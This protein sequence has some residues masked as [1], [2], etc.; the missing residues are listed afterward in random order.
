MLS[1]WLLRLKTLVRRERVEAEFDEELRYHLDRE[2]QRNVARGMT[3]TEARRAA[4]RAFGDPGRLKEEARDTW[5]W[6]LL[7][8]FA[9]EARYA[10][11][12]LWHSPGFTVV[13]VLS[14]G[15]GIGSASTLFGV[16]DA[17]DFR[18][19]PFPD[20]ERLVWLAERLDPENP[21]CPGCPWDVSSSTAAAW[22]EGARSLGSVVGWANSGA[23]FAEGD[24]S[25]SARVSHVSPGFFG[26]LG[27]ELQLGRGFVPDDTLSGAEPVA[28]LSHAMWE[29]AFGGDPGVVGRRLEY[30]RDMTLEERAGATIVGVLPESFRFE[31]DRAFWTPLGPGQGSG[32]RSA[33]SV[34]ARLDPGITRAMAETE[35][36]GL[37]RALAAAEQR[38]HRSVAVLPLR[39]RLGWGSGEGRGILFSIAGLVLLIATLNVAALSLPRC[40]S[41]R[42]EMA[43]RT[44]LGAPRFRLVRQLLVEGSLV[45]LLGGAVGV[46]VAL[47]GVGA[48]RTWFRLEHSVLSVVV[49]LRV[50][51]FIGVTALA[52]GLVTAALPAVRIARREPGTS[53]RQRPTSGLLSRAGGVASGLLAAQMGAGLAL[54]AGAGILASDFME[55]RYRDLGFEP[56]GLHQAYL[57]G[58][59][60]ARFLDHPEGW[61]PFIE[62]V[63]AR[64][65]AVPGVVDASLE[66]GSARSP[67]VVR[68][69][70]A[71]GRTLEDPHPRV[72][73]VD[74]GYF[75]TLGTKV[76]RGR[77][78]RET[79]R[80]GASGVAIVNESAAFRFWPDEDPLGRQLFVGDA[81]GAGEW[82]TVVGVAA[83]VE[84]GQMV[85]RHWSV[86]YRPLQQAPIY[87]AAAALMVRLADGSPRMVAA[88]QAAVREGLGH[89]TSAL[90]SVE[91]SLGQRYRFER[92]NTLALNLFAGFALLLTAMG[93]YGSVAYRVGR[94]TR[95]IGIRMALGAQRR[96]VLGLVAGHVAKITLAGVVL[97]LL[98]AKA[99]A[100]GLRAFVS[101]TSPDDPRV[102]L[103]AA[104]VVGAAVLVAAWIPARRA[105]AVD[106]AL[107]LRAD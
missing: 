107:A 42:G 27:T 75:E 63:L 32:P 104:L 25:R 76:L 52:V 13:A 65:R 31:S 30:Y 67:E 98:G 26:M 100:R 8:E 29:R 101:A 1:R 46:M 45:G 37:A 90:E 102:L 47:A 6:P 72:L 10:G 39:D 95:E 5:R 91:G 89:P 18:P 7:D 81:A 82:L 28:V 19:L 80:R 103:G 12:R 66:H 55:I 51:A 61:R 97:G 87:H 35:L 79:D 34:F 105:T 106:P 24:A 36:N 48:A 49:D 73:A 14:L 20:A 58:F 64:T 11:R 85:E 94:Q 86:V 4:R 17:L 70:G 23:Y 3:P 62:D 92:F 38:D 99:V 9:E 84:R 78:F 88:V 60:E 96:R 16:I 93:T 2:V 68:S 83:D 69:G 77:D 15:F 56:K 71:D 33:V 74:H 22:T 57:F 54:L 21:R 53:L 59:G 44:A 40:M 50:F 43:L 41:R